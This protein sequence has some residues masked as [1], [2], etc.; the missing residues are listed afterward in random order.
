MVAIRE[1]ASTTNPA[2]AASSLSSALWLGLVTD[3]VDIAS[4]M[5]CSIEGNVSHLAQATLG[6]GA[7]LFSAIAAQHML[8]Q[9]GKAGD[10][11]AE[12]DG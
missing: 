9:R 10:T 12:R 4:V 6:G 1:N 2:A 7:V 5:V 3:S 8:R 11:E